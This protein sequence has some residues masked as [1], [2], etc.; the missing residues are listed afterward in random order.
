MKSPSVS[1]SY[2]TAPRRAG[3]SPDESTSVA[4]RRRRHVL[5]LLF[6]WVFFSVQILYC[7]RA[8]RMSYLP[9]GARAPLIGGGWYQDLYQPPSGAPGA[10]H[11]ELAEIRCP[12][13]VRFGRNLGIE[14]IASASPTFLERTQVGV[15]SDQVGLTRCLHDPTVRI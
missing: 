14:A 8:H 1:P 13:P 10:W 7:D 5:P 11:Q 2:S 9:T 4:A 12:N 6:L 15:S 3:R